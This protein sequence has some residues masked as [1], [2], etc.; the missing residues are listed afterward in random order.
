M[1]GARGGGGRGTVESTLD[2]LDAVKTSLVQ[3]TR[4]PSS[5]PKRIPF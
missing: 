3:R 4:D 1:R 2:P 5:S